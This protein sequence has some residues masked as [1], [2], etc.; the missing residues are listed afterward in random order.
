MKKWWWL[1]DDGNG[2]CDVGGS[3]VTAADDNDDEHDNQHE[4]YYHD[5]DLFH[6][7]DVIALH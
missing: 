3:C 2:D 4:D 5:H 6:N 7:A 1:Y